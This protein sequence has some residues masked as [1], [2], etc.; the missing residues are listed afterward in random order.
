MHNH[1]DVHG[2]FPPEKKFRDAAG[3][4]KLSWRV[5]ILPYIEQL[6][7]YNEFR[8]DEPWDSPHNKP[9]I[10][11]M[12]DVFKSSSLDEMASRVK[13]GHTTLLAPSGKGAVFG[14]AKPV[15][16]QDIRDGTSN[17]VVLVHVKPELAVPWTAPDD[18]A[19]DQE[20]PGKGLHLGN[21][22]KFLAA[23]ADGGVHSL[24]GDLNAEVFLGIFGIN[25][26]TPIAWEAIR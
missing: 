13:P 19:F 14:G 25:D 2:S 17:T 10:E 5:H 11:K 15:K 4:S 7:L 9:L 23:T 3:A 16:F 12:P 26:G 22:G 6:P 8:L 1:H 20:A 21:D 18:Y 24:R